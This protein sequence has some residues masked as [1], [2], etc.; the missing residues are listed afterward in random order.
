MPF[1]IKQITDPRFPVEFPDG[2]V[3]EYDP[4]AVQEAIEK[5]VGRAA[6]ADPEAGVSATVY[7]AVRSAFGLPLAADVEGGKAV[8]FDGTD[9][10]GKPGTF[11]RHQALEVQVELGR[12]IAGLDVSKK[13][14]ALGQSSNASSA[15]PSP[16]SKR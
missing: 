2:K 7:D 5:Y 1:K 9:P 3:V 15:S 6:A 4:F 12:F 8:Y 10:E 14:L 11:T 13:A 16:N